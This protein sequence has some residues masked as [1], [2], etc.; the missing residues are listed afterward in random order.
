MEELAYI[1]C[2]GV[3]MAIAVQMHGDPGHS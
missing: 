3:P 2:G 1:H